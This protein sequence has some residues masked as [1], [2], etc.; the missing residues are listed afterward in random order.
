MSEK[1]SERIRTV[2]IANEWLGTQYQTAL[3]WADE[4]AALEA[5]LEAAKEFVEMAGYA[6]NSGGEYPA[7]CQECGTNNGAHAR[8][9][10]LQAWLEEQR[11]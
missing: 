11:E 8:A 6:D 3:D 1:L 5:K 9:C 7:E 4:V 10:R 2:A